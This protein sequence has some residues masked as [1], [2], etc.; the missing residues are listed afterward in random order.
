[1]LWMKSSYHGRR[2][3]FS[4]D[5]PLCKV[6]LDSFWWIVIGFWNTDHYLLRWEYIFI[7]GEEA[8]KF[9]MAILPIKVNNLWVDLG[10]N[11]SWG[12]R[13]QTRREWD[14]STVTKELFLMYSSPS[15]NQK[16]STF[17]KIFNEPLYSKNWLGLMYQK[18]Q[19]G[20]PI[21]IPRWAV[22]AHFPSVSITVESDNNFLLVGFLRM[23]NELMDRKASLTQC[24]HGNDSDTICGLTFFSCS[25]IPFC[26]NNGSEALTDVLTFLSLC[27]FLWYDSLVILE[28]DLVLKVRYCVYLR[29]SWSHSIR[30]RSC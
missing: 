27:F 3:I 17:K 21:S 20:N 1:M 25:L 11:E 26:E 6:L 30:E 9:E 2:D 7:S 16:A 12:R 22:Q 24:L 5:P 15:W 10:M 28:H 23:L 4:K 29:L 8:G 13:S 14:D 19:K 18:D